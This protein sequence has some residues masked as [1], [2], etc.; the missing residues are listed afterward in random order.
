VSVQVSYKKQLYLIISLIIIL[1]IV[2][3]VVVNIWLY[4][5]YRCSFEVS[6]ISKENDPEINRK[7]CL[8][9]LGYDTSKQR[10]S[11]VQGTTAGDALSEDT[12]K[13]LVYINSEGFRSP[14]FYKDKPEN[15]YRIFAIGGSTTFST[16]VID[17]QTYPFYLQQ[18][19]DQTDLGLEVEIINTGWPRMWSLTETEMIKNRLIAFEPDLFIVLD[20]WNDLKQNTKSNTQASA[21]L[22]KERWLEICDLGEKYHFDTIISLQA[23]VGAGKKILSEQESLEYLK[24]PVH[25]LRLVA[26]PEYVEQLDEL[27]NNCSVVA[28]LRGLFDY[29]SEPIYFDTV[30]TGAKGNQIIAEKFYQLSLPIVLEHEDID[31]NED[32]EAASFGEIETQL[33][34]NNYDLFTEN[35]YNMLKDIV[36]SYKTPRVFSLIFQ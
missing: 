4:Y 6:E 13:N 26:Y 32:Y 2:V 18:L 22:W 34:S 12:D 25:S 20:G 14:E 5:F 30:H 19:Y 24:T 17:N 11:K 35:F 15:T 10:L 7:I 33:I 27:K 28:D 8:S 29:I 23:M 16:G 9:H 1:L 21:T 3:E 36:F 31:F